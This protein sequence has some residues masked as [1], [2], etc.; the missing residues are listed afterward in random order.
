MSVKNNAKN[1]SCSKVAQNPR[2][3]SLWHEIK[4]YSDHVNPLFEL[5]WHVVS[6]ALAQCG[7]ITHRKDSP[8]NFANASDDGVMLFSL[9]C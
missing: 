4:I 3:V 5:L 6:V 2:R 8:Y 1:C 9:H 7:I